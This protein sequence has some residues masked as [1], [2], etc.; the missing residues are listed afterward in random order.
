MK[1]INHI[2]TLLFS[3]PLNKPTT[4]EMLKKAGKKCKGERNDNFF[5]GDIS[6][7][8]GGNFPPHNGHR[9]GKGVDVWESVCCDIRRAEYNKEDAL[10]LAKVFIGCGA[11]RVLFN[12]KYVVDQCEKAIA[13]SG[14]HHHFHVDIK[15]SESPKTNQD[16]WLCKKC[17]SSNSLACPHKIKEE[18]NDVKKS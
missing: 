14:H 10:E 3:N 11:A 7:Y 4:Q 9:D 17:A 1:V 12:C 15:E 16:E 2:S 6:K 8:N 13:L 18:T 5:V